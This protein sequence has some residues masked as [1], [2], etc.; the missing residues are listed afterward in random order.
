MD[1]ENCKVENIYKPLCINND[2]SVHN[3]CNSDLLHKNISDKFIKNN[4]EESLSTVLNEFKQIQKEQGLIGKSWNNIKCLFGGG[5]KKIK[6]QINQ[7]RKGEISL[8]QLKEFID[9]YKKGQEMSVDVVGDIVSGMLA[10]GAVFATP[11]TGGTSLL[12]AAGVGSGVKTFIKS[13]DAITSGRKYGLKDTFYDIVTG[14][15]NGAFAPITNALGGAIGTGVAKILGLNTLKSAVFETGVNTAGKSFLSR[16]LAKQGVQYVAKESGKSGFKTVLAKSV[17][18]GADMATDGSVSGAVD[19]FARSFASGDIKNMWTNIKQGFIGGLIAAPII[20]GGFKLAG[21]AGAK[22]KQGVISQPKVSFEGKT[23]VES[24]D[25]IGFEKNMKELNMKELNLY[26]SSSKFSKCGPKKNKW[27]TVKEQTPILKEK[28]ISELETAAKKP[29]SRVHKAKNAV[30]ISEAVDYRKIIKSAE[31]TDF[32]D[33]EKFALRLKSKIK[34]QFANT[35]VDEVRAIIKTLTDMGIKESHA[36]EIL[37]RLS[38]FTSYKQM[39]EFGKVLERLGVD[40]IYG[41]KNISLNSV[42]NYVG[43]KKGQFYEQADTLLSKLRIPDHVTK[44]KVFFLDDK[45]LDFIRK[46]IQEKNNSFLSDVKTGKIVFAAIDGWNVKSGNSYISYGMF[47][48]EQSLAD[49]A[50]IV[51]ERMKKGQSFEDALNGDFSR[52]A[53]TILEQLRRTA[54]LSE[55]IPIEMIRNGSAVGKNSAEAISNR[56]AGKMPDAAYIRAAIE[57]MINETMDGCSNMEKDAARILLS[58]YYDNMISVYSSET[59]AKK[60]KLKH[61]AIIDAV[62]RMGKSAD[63]IV[64]VFPKAQKSFAI[65]NYQY[66]RVN[67]I[68]SDKFIHYNGYDMPDSLKG[69]VC[70]ILDDIIGSGGSLISEQF[71]YAQFI[72]DIQSCPDTR[73]IFSPMSSLRQGEKNILTAIKEKMR[74]GK[75]LFMPTDIVDYEKFCETL[76]PFEK[77]LLSKI[78]GHEGYLGGGAATGMPYMLPDNDSSAAGLLLNEMLCNFNENSN[79][80]FDA[81]FISS[82]LDKV[83]KLRNAIIEKQKSMLQ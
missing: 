49:I 29:L 61:E 12:L 76:S 18:Y 53:K 57:T 23:T 35:S 22:L 47:G 30:G 1:F 15:I 83:K 4:E 7:Y 43:I 55:E 80:N 37:S 65:I 32:A 77:N 5:S 52:E 54:G 67:G 45:G 14:S 51:A 41:T 64:Y 16:L 17:T 39:R 40:E 34:A 48:Q 38:Q 20:G 69:K 11:F 8:E 3:F 31:G 2:A 26:P 42:L 9:K 74:K 24:L 71:K 56:I 50:K 27:Y 81:S 13:F 58:K 6:K 28:I 62:R 59:L 72:H 36:Q 75:D 70:V 25:I 82:I 68:N 60:L 46:A 19:G 10:L 73:I 63:D 78:L 21:K 79:K 33:P 66:G 44:K